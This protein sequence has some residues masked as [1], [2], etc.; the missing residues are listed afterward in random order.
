MRKIACD[1]TLQLVRRS[2]SAGHVDPDS[3]EVVKSNL[4]TPQGS[5]LSP[6]LANIVLN[7]LDQAMEMTKTKFEKGIKRARNKEYDALGSKI[8]N[9]RKRHPGSPD[10]KRLA[11][12]KRRTP[13]LMIN[14]PNFKRMM[15]LRYADDFVILIAGS[16]NDAHMMRSRV[17]DYLEK[18]CG[19]T[20]NLDKTLITNT[21]EGFDFLGASCIKPTALKAGL[22]RTRSGNPG[23][24][25]MRMRIMIPI[26]KLLQKVTTSGF[27]KTDENNLPVPTARK[28]LVNFEH[29]E[30]ITFYNHRISGLV[31]FYGFAHNYTGLRKIIMVLQFSC[32]LTLAL[33]FKLRTKK[34]AFKRF[35]Y[36]LGDPETG[37][38]LKFPKTF[39][40][41]HQFPSTTESRADE[42]LRVSW[43]NKLTKSSLNKACV[44]CESKTNVEM[45]HIRQVKDVKNKIRTGNSTYQQ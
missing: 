4:G 14:D 26:K 32:A 33:K 36:L 19:L 25:R 37:K 13:S 2:L 15:Y 21:R 24:F 3:G 17:S 12:L 41:K 30:I 5:I 16:A 43:F 23:K 10:I 20:L 11:I 39:K 45:H 28:D 27:A 22:F 29:H 40:V 44:I 38:H 8:Q 6:L 35:G 31:N 42:I 34:Q 7:E 1:K 18:K 9:L